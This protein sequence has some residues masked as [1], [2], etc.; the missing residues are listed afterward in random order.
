MSKKFIIRDPFAL[1]RE[2]VLKSRGYA[3]WMSNIYVAAAVS[4][5]LKPCFGPKGMSK[6]VIDKFSEGVVTSHGAEILEKLDLHHPV[7]KL[8]REA[9]K[10]VDITVGDGTKTTV[11]LIGEL[12]KKAAN[13]ATR[14]L[15]INTIIKGYLIAYNTALK[16]LPKSSKALNGLDSNS[17][18]GFV[19]TILT[20]RG[21][22]NADYL[23]ELVTQAITAAIRKDDGKRVLDRDSV[24]IVKKAGGSIMESRVVNG[25]IIEKGVAHPAMPRV[26]KNPKIAV[27]NMAL[28]IDEFKHL[29]SFKYHID[30]NKP[31]S[32]GQFLRE[33][34][35]LVQSMVE[36]VL[37][38][39]ASVVICR[40]KMG[41]IAKQLLAKAGVMGISRLLNE[42]EFTSVAKITG[43]KIVSSVE[44]ITEEDLGR[45]D[46]IRE[47]RIGTERVLV[48]EGCNSAGGVTVLL[49]GFSE[50]VLNDIEH[51]FKDSI[52]YISSSLEGPAY[53]PGGGAVEETLAI[54]IR[55]EAL[56]HVG[57][58]QE[59]IMAYADALEAVPRLLA[60][61]SGHDPVEVLSELR[62]KHEIGENNYGFD[63][64]SG[65]VCDTL[66]SGIV[67]SYRM[68]EQVLKTTFETAVM[69]L[70]VD[71]L[72][73]RRYAKR[74]EGELGGE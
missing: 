11:I 2:G 15:K 52:T 18:R 16:S 53:L 48:I 5:V 44:D 13:L 20:G 8:L 3:A 60:E 1:Y 58:E 67:E 62:A 9:S 66:K 22:G 12:L 57:K 7:A 29:Q 41:D 70:R 32:V 49:R 61:N 59:A 47:E 25:V 72:V 26:I 51:A 63:P 30:I 4:D 24:K 71:E 33:E 55:R 73:D 40:K 17:I 36:K 6:L 68:K 21:L 39:G 14:Q 37:S 31:G 10:T 64:L 23:S 65:K 46:L 50:N 42:K 69:L 54:A 19:S 34:E 35:E 28:K 56:G 74:H 27:L 43:A 45:A 38:V